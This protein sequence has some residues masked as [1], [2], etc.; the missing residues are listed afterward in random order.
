MMCAAIPHDKECL[1]RQVQQQ[2]CD[3]VQVSGDQNANVLAN[4]MNRL[5]V[6][7]AQLLHFKAVLSMMDHI[8]NLLDRH[9]A[10]DVIDR[11][12][13]A[14]AI[15]DVDSV[16]F[17]VLIE[18][19][20]V[21]CATLQSDL[22]LHL[23][24]D[25][26]H[27]HVVVL[28]VLVV[29]HID[30]SED[31]IVVTIEQLLDDDVD[32][33]QQDSETNG[34]LAGFDVHVHRVCVLDLAIKVRILA[35]DRK[36]IVFL[37]CL[38]MLLQVRQIVLLDE[39]RF[40][41][42]NIFGWLALA[43]RRPDILAMVHA[44]QAMHTRHNWP[45]TFLFELNNLEAKFQR[46]LALERCSAFSRLRDGDSTSWFAFGLRPP[47][48]HTHYY[49][50]FDVLRS[51]KIFLE[52]RKYM[53]WCDTHFLPPCCCLGHTLRAYVLFCALMLASFGALCA[54]KIEHTNL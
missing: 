29:N 19:E 49:D 9:A 13:E 53:R 46:I 35:I 50:P 40:E 25:L 45:I 52:P 15:R 23:L 51:T 12:E 33:R 24:V 6:D 7:V 31:L 30:V 36:L 11:Q 14:R 3:L 4:V 22:F 8:N 16:H 39:R 42:M 48:T 44:K 17:V 38:G 47:H 34:V 21:H 54:F 20:E 28:F 27:V 32:D 18:L 5:I 37:P 43:I 41:N 2:I 10:P 1:H 26:L